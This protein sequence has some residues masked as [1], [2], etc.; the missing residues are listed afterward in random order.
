[1]TKEKHLDYALLAVRT[2]P[3]K[4]RLNVKAVQNNINLLD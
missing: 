1:M 4:V 3:E 2:K